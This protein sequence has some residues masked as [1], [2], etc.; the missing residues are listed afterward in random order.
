MRCE[1]FTTW[2]FPDGFPEKSNLSS[3]NNENF[4]WCKTE[5]G[6]WV[7]PVKDT[8]KTLDL[9]RIRSLID[10]HN[11]ENVLILDSL[12]SAQSNRLCVKDHVNRSG[13]S[14]LRGATH[15]EG[16]PMF[17]DMGDIYRPVDGYMPVVVHTVG[18]DRWTKQPMADQIIWSKWAAI[19]SVPFAYF[20]LPVAVVN[21]LPVKGD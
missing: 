9:H 1:D 16:Y 7:A 5:N 11:I 10:Q 17:P 12:K 2:F 15:Q 3:D 14:F 13:R 21:Q 8:L 18:P 4:L 19:W 20:K 6:L